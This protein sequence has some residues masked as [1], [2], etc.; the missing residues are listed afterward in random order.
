MRDD[1]VLLPANKLCKA[2]TGEDKVDGPRTGAV[3]QTMTGR[4]SKWSWWCPPGF[5][6]TRATDIYNSGCKKGAFLLPTITTQQQI[7]SNPNNINR[8]PMITPVIA[9]WE[10]REL[11][12]E[13]RRLREVEVLSPQNQ[14]TATA[15]ADPESAMCNT[16]TKIVCPV[17]ATALQSSSRGSPNRPNRRRRQLLESPKLHQHAGAVQT[18]LE[19]HPGRVG[20]KRRCPGSRT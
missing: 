16:F 1:N 11:V 15:W 3:M 7:L 5:R 19:H 8:R 9:Q 6:G 18:R 17:I 2:T 4:N 14:Q 20:K 12:E 10:H 13:H